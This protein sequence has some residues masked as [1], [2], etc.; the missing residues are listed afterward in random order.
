MTNQWFSG[1][2]GCPILPH[3]VFEFL[4][5]SQES[6]DYLAMERERESFSP[7]YIWLFH[8]TS[9]RDT[10]MHAESRGNRLAASSSGKGLSMGLDISWDKTAGVGS[11]YICFLSTYCWSIA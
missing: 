6:L 10:T 11:K 2:M 1:T 5:K 4:K 9:L 8:A 3:M 7:G